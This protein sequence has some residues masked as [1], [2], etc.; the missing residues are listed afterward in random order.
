MKQGDKVLIFFI[1]L[2]SVM[3]YVFLYLAGRDDRNKYISVQVEGNEYKRLTFASGNNSYEYKIDTAEGTNVIEI[4]EEKIQMIKA[5]CP[6]KLCIRQGYISRV[7]EVLVCIPNKVV[8]EIK[9]DKN[10]D[11][12]DGINY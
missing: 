1:V 8:V 4:E 3:S 11:Q 2:L 5:D 6:D 9:S 7:G 10:S 12:L